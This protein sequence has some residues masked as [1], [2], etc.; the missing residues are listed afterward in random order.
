MNFQARRQDDILDINL[1]PLIDVLL[2]ILIFLAA[3]T[4]FSRYSQLDIDL[5]Q[6]QEGAQLEGATTLTISRDGIVGLDGHLLTGNTVADI[7]AA[8]AAHAPEP[9]NAVLI[10]QA[11]AQAHHGAVVSAMEAAQQVGIAKIVFAT[12]T[13][14]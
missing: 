6:V 10:I 12:Q 1:I 13:A 2:V 14:Q 4:T 5:P 8:L 9:A 7:A 3:T 11:D